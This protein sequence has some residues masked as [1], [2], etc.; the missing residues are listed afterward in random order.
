MRRQRGANFTGGASFLSKEAGK[1]W[2]T[3][4]GGDRWWRHGWVVARLADPRRRRFFGEQLADGG[5]E[6][7]EDGSLVRKTAPEVPSTSTPKLIIEKRE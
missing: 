2:A 5:K 6:R 3:A 4:G 1:V 7:V